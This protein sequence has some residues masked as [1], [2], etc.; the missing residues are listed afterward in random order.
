[1]LTG[2]AAAGIFGG[3]VIGGALSGAVGGYVGGFTLGF[4]NNTYFGDGTIGGGIRAGHSSG[5]PGAIL[6][7]LIGGI[8]ESPNGGYVAP[9]WMRN[10]LVAPTTPNATSNS[11]DTGDVTFN[12]ATDANGRPINSLA[13]NKA[14]SSYGSENS[15]VDIRFGNDANQVYHTFR[16]IDKLGIDRIAVQNA[17]GND[18]SSLGQINPGP[19]PIRAV[20]VNGVYI[21]YSLYMLPDGVIN[22]GSIRPPR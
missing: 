22:V 8:A 15:T 13:G 1:M 6:G 20:N 21:K 10:G 5:I 9:D 19:I 17:I 18:L 16:H 2:G 12:G 11:T 3:G 4:G 14:G 7:G